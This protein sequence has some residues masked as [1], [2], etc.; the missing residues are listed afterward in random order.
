MVAWKTGTA[1][2]DVLLIHD[3]LCSAHLLISNRLDEDAH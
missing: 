3:A 2:S 1:D